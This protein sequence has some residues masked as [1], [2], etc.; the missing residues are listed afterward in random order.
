MSAPADAPADA[1]A[2][3]APAATATRPRLDRREVAGSLGDMGTF[4]PLLV[5][6]A[7]QNGLHFATA[8][9][10][11]GLMNVVAGLVF[12][13]PMAV[14]PMKAIAAVALTQGL[15]AS[16]IVAAG[17]TVGAVLLLLGLTGLIDRLDKAIPRSVVRGLQ[18]ALGAMLLVKATRM[19]S[20]TG[21]W[22]A[23]DSYVTALAATAI[24]FALS[25]S[26]RVPAA[27]VVFGSGLLLV[28][29]RH[30][31]VV[32][33]LRWEL[34]LPALRPPAAADFAT[35]FPVAVLP[36]LPLT[37]LNS[38]VAVCALATDLFPGRRATPR[39][40]AVSVGLMNLI[41]APFGGMPMCH[42]AGGLAG[43]Y[44][45]GARTGGSMVFLGTAKMLLAV[46]LGSS[47]VALVAS[48]PSSVLGVMLAFTG[49]EL[50]W[51]VRHV[52]K[53]SAVLVVAATTVVTLLSGSL[54][55]G[56]GA[57]LALAL[58]S[59]TPR[60]RRYRPSKALSEGLS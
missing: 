9:F 1:P 20:Q 18:V 28:A 7:S 16:Q 47:L 53:S 2:A 32:A 49:I 4:L 56:F 34:A 41:A 27:L 10:F 42:G 3:A 40:V 15:T 23:P 48:F 37:I 38:V 58:L 8:L 30:P 26:R 51:V 22:L 33:G 12:A 11:A 13:M 59:P 6:M 21:A 17:A 44:R 29:W 31:E 19:I 52:R 50:M 24:I 14:Q 46:L 25:Y 55:A 39:S 43:Q 54:L 36:Q 45:F 57:G 5:G 60:N 35:A